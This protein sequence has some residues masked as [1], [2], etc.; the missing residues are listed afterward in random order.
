MDEAKDNVGMGGMQTQESTYTRGLGSLGAY[1]KQI[2]PFSVYISITSNDESIGFVTKTSGDS[3][4]EVL[5]AAI[6]KVP[7]EY[8]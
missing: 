1:R 8:K 5:A 7:A 6:A 2:S 4:K 3:I